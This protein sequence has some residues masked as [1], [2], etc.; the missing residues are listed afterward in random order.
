[1]EAG[2]QK[3]GEPRCYFSDTT[4]CVNPYPV[5][6]LED[7]AAFAIFLDAQTQ[8]K[9]ASAGFG[10]FRAGLDYSGVRQ[11]AAAHGVAWTW[12]L[13]KRIQSCER[14]I[15]E[16]DRVARERKE[17]QNRNQQEAGIPVN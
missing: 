9:Y 7:E 3:F 15:L 12:P 14:A 8:W 5:L 6:D 4:G 2:R 16:S 11:V 17:V 10:V 13:L 1:M